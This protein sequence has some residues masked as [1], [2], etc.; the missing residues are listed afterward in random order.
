MRFS[1]L[2]PAILLLSA[3][4]STSKLASDEGIYWV[5]SLEKPCTPA[6]ES[7]CLELQQG[8]DLDAGAWD[9]QIEDIHGFAFEEGYLY[10]VVLREEDSI[11]SDA[12]ALQLELVS[13]LEKIED[14]K[15]ALEGAWVLSSL[16]GESLPENF[17]PPELEFRLRQHQ[18]LGM[19]G[20]N[21]YTGSIA[22]VGDKD[23]SFGVA[24]GTRMA[25]PHMEVSHSY[26]QG[27][28]DCRHYQIKD[29][30]LRLLDEKGKELLLFS[31]AP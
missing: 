16:G 7:T 8:P 25:C 18:Y 12:M 4:G 3:C 6:D 19:D 30:E 17:P 26:N 11:P 13:V 14:P 27:L 15:L 9:L 31:K 22:V 21:R 29:E 23:L 5:N 28:G 20:C 24:A 10:K 2:L 1:L